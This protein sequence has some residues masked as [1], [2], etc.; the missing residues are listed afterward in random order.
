MLHFHYTR[1]LYDILPGAET[2]KNEADK[3]GIPIQAKR[4][5]CLTDPSE[6][7]VLETIMHKSVKDRGPVT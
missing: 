6:F 3:P 1:A 2:P 5:H 7:Q 4:G